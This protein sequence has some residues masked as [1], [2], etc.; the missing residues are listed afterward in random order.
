ML[1]GVIRAG[2]TT[3]EMQR[4]IKVGSY[5]LSSTPVGQATAVGLNAFNSTYGIHRGWVPSSNVLQPDIPPKVEIKLLDY[6]RGDGANGYI[7]SSQGGE[8]LLQ[9]NVG[10]D[11]N[12]YFALD[13]ESVTVTAT[14]EV[15]MVLPLL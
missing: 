7:T 13:G 5:R 12:I 1:G 14:V 10:V 3:P 9:A 6:D 2:N 4:T 15:L 8:L 11:P